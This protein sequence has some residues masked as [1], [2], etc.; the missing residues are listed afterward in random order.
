MGKTF[1]TF[2]AEPMTPEEPVEDVLICI[3]EPC[4]QWKSGD[5]LEDHLLKYQEEAQEFAEIL[6]K[7]LPQALRYRLAVTLMG[8]VVK[9]NG[10][11]HTDIPH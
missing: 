7:S 6:R 9:E 5:R 4:P 10:Y 11:V 1:K 8:D 3:T 2:K